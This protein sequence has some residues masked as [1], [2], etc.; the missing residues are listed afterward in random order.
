MRSVLSTLFLT[1]ICIEFGRAF[2]LGQ[3]SRVNTPS[4]ADPVLYPKQSEIQETK[5][6]RLFGEISA[7]NER[8]H[9][10]EVTIR[11]RKLVFALWRL[12]SFP[13]VSLSHGNE[14]R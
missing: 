7:R 2:Q 14:L 5:S 12:F 11:V 6:L 13:L 8:E 9:N 3:L 10:R 4:F 1:I